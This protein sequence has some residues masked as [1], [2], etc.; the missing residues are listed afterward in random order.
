MSI[1]H[2]VSSQA[3]VV[4]VEVEVWL[5]I[6]HAASISCRAKEEGVKESVLRGAFDS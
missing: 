2:W 3:E 5:H 6:E 1:E 4:V